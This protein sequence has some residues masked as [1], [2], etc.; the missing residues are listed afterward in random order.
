MFR[1]HSRANDHLLTAGIVR[2]GVRV[3]GFVTFRVLSVAQL[4]S[5]CMAGSVAIVKQCTNRDD[6]DVKTG[7]RFQ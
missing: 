2:L 5:S 7:E 6:V 4:F 3:V 1:K